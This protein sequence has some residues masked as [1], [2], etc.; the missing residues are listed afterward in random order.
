[1]LMLLTFAHILL[2]PLLRY[3]LVGLDLPHDTFHKMAALHMLLKAV[4]QAVSNIKFAP[5][6]I[7]DVPILH[8]F[9]PTIG[10]NFFIH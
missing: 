2:S 5:D 4:I 6:H 9:I 10:A 7:L 8:A 3:F 1:M